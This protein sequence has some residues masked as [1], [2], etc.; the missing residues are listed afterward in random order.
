MLS[1]R[2]SPLGAIRG[3]CVREG[4]DVN[5]ALSRVGPRRGR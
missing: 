4:H 5:V 1:L 2:L 3:K